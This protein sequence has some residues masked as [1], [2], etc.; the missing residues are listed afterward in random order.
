[1]W[2]NIENGFPNEPGNYY[3]EYLDGKRNTQYFIPAYSEDWIKMGI[4]KWL[5]D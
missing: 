5:S 1:M 4:I 3:V 2:K